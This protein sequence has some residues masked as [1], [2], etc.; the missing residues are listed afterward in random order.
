MNSPTINLLARRAALINQLEFILNRA[1]V[2]QKRVLEAT[3]YGELDGLDAKETVY[4]R[5]SRALL[6]NIR[7]LEQEILEAYQQEAELQM[8]ARRAARIAEIARLAPN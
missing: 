6:T 4:R 5:R 2:S 3:T 1:R 7:V 8:L